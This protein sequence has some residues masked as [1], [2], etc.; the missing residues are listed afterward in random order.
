MTVSQDFDDPFRVA[1]DNYIAMGY[2]Q[3]EVALGLASHQS[4]ADQDKVRFCLWRG[5]L[6]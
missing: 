6:V 4:H 1:V 5:S 2:E 3:E